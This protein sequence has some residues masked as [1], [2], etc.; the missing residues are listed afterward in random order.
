MTGTAVSTLRPTDL[1]SARDAM[2]AVPG[3]VAITG[4]GTADWAGRL[5][6][7]DA[8]L[9]TTALSGVLTHNP[10]DMTASV[11][12]GTPLRELAEELAPHGQRVA[13]DAA[14]VARGATVGGLIATADSGPSALAYGSLR[15]LV[16]GATVV[17][18]DGTVAHSGGHVIKN[19]AGYD[20]T[21]LLQGSH[22]TLALMVEIVLR[23]HPIPEQ[24]ATVAVQCALADASTHVQRL[25]MSPLEPVALEWA[26][27]RLL[28]RLE[29]TAEAIDAR[30]ARLVELL[31]GTRMDDEVWQRHAELV[32]G[33]P[34][35]AP[36]KG[37]RLRIGCLPSRLPGLLAELPATAVTAGFGTG[38][39]TV[40][41]PSDAVDAAHKIVYAA[42][43]TSVLRDRPRDCDAPAWGPAP[44][45]L[46][47]LRA[48]KS[49]LDPDG[50]LGP[51]RF[52]PWM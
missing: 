50:R 21:K 52:A 26:D 42:G 16:I 8:V 43:G 9:D 48:V 49:T 12:A 36:T 4:A 11:L 2:L 34:D 32:G 23:L 35:G 28:A 10:G 13:L 19:V 47:V 37:A 25:L 5:E 6:P 14:R 24:V 29:G 27:G 1:A 41:M 22:G 30:A 20:L 15:D 45:A 39:A 33:R 44:S 51:G 3:R 46:P 7:V 40:T 17:L 18:A 31:G 38:I